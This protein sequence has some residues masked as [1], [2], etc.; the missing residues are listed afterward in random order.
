MAPVIGN[1]VRVFRSGGMAWQRV[2]QCGIL[3]EQQ[4]NFNQQ[5]LCALQLLIE[6]DHKPAD[7]LRRTHPSVNA[8]K[9]RS[10]TSDVGRNTPCPP[11]AGGSTFLVYL[12]R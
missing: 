7:Q 9:A 4:S 5:V 10:N 1:Q 11:I 12:L 8:V 2:G 3:V 6:D